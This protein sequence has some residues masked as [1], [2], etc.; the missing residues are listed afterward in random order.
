V[1][2]ENW[3]VQLQ[4]WANQYAEELADKPGIFGVVIGGSIAR[5]QE[6]RH[7][8]LE[9]GVLVEGKDESIPYFNVN[10][11][12]GVEIIQLI[13]PQIETQITQVEAG[14][15]T[16]VAIWPIQLWKC[17]V[18]H[19]PQG[20]LEQFKRQFDSRL[21]T[22]EVLEKRIENLR[23]DIRNRLTEANRR[24]AED[25]PASALVEVRHAMNNVILAFHWANGEL[26][27]SQNRTDSRLLALCQRY[28]IM[29]VY[30]LYHDVFA[31][32]DATNVIENIWPK[33]R[34]SVLEITRLWGDSA[35]EFFVHAV[36]SG[37]QWGENSG[38]LTVYR[39]YIPTIGG[40]S[41]SLQ[42]HLDNQNWTEQNKDLVE[43]LGLAD[44]KNETVSQFIS[45]I[46]ACID[47]I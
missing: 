15:L 9:V 32:S 23:L 44:I 5:G 13:L 6:W 19:D 29:P 36:D 16:P 3:R 37:F 33:V 22:N 25:K 21:F 35:H 26:P 10:A 45:R 12:R 27:R 41:H 40:T 24:L 28:S 2:T 46:E 7:S 42:Q 34:N 8:D 30:T 11:G 31:L 4:N 1:V 39:L 14:D 43:F 20:I 17:Q 18:V 47:G 38:I